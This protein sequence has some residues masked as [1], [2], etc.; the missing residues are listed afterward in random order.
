MVYDS[1]AGGYA[2]SVEVIPGYANGL[3]PFGK[4]RSVKVWTTN[5]YYKNANPNFDFGML[6]TADALGWTTGWLGLKPA[7]NADLGLVVLCGYPDDRGRTQAMYYAGGRTQWERGQNWWE[8][9]Y[10]LQYEFWT[11]NG[12]SGGPLINNS[13]YVVGVHTGGNSNYNYA[14]GISP[15]FLKWTFN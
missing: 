15:E 6:R 8:P 13:F 4:T 2:K 11:D 9:V 3:A 5:G 1:D 14:V 12:M 7:D 10:R